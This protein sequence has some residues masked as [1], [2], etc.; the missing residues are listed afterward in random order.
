[1]ISW[2]DATTFHE[3]G[4]ALHGLSSNVTYPT[5]PVLPLGIMWNFPLKFWSAGL[6]PEV[7]NKFALHYKTNEP[8][9]MALVE[10]IDEAST[11]NEGFSTVETIASSLID[12]KLHLAGD[13]QLTRQHLSVKH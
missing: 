4:H 11:F 7:L 12:M 13:T 3:F 9:P 10:R 2:T 6:K 1:L 5:L 8:I